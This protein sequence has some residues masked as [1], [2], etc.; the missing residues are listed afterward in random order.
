MATRPRRLYPCP[1]GQVAWSVDVRPSTENLVS[2][3]LPNRPSRSS[4]RGL[5]GI[6]VLAISATA[7]TG[8]YTPPDPTEWGE[9]AKKN[10]VEACT[11]IV[12]VGDNTTT[13]TPLADRATCECI[14]DAMVEDYN[15]TWDDMKEYEKKVAET[16]EGDPRPTPPS[17]LTKAVDRCESKGPDAPSTDADADGGDADSDAT[18]A[19]DAPTTTA[20]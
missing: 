4:R 19:T 7:L 17:E 11:T 12:D 5:A 20:G 16:G 9:A 18:E 10:F 13:T 14:Y 3:L 2:P 1:A 6:G 15:L 8:C